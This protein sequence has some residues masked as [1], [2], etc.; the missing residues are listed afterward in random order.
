[1]TSKEPRFECFERIYNPVCS[2]FKGKSGIR[3][4]DFFKGQEHGKNIDTKSLNGKPGH[5]HTALL[6]NIF[7]NKQKN[8]HIESDSKVSTH[9]NMIF[10]HGQHFHIQYG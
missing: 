3:P 2:S 5:P 9:S 1:M 10:P 7:S 8:P 4:I 6:L